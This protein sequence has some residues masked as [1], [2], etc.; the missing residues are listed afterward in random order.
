MT[1][2]PGGIFDLGSN[3]NVDASQGALISSFLDS[4]GLSETSLTQI[5]VSTT[6][7]NTIADTV[8][9]ATFSV[10]SGSTANVV[11]SGSSGKTLIVTGSG[12]ASIAGS[13][14]GDS[15]LGGSGSD[16]VT[17]GLGDD[18]VRGGA[19]NDILLGGMKTVGGLFGSGEMR[20]PVALRSAGVMKAAG[21]HLGLLDGADHLGGRACRVLGGGASSHL[22][23]SLASVSHASVRMTRRA[24]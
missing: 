11:L 8:S 13:A 21:A 3:T 7:T 22:R 20:L 6:G 19:G 1:T 17:G 15:V 23:Q 14:G 5:T 24:S 16:S 9:S 4:L 10:S 18:Q 2:V 12:N